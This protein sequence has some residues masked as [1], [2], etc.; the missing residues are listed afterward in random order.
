LNQGCPPFLLLSLR[1]L[2]GTLALFL[3]SRFLYTIRQNKEK[4][5]KFNKKGLSYGFV[6]GLLIFIVYG[7]QTV[8]ANYTTPAKNGVF[9]GLYII[10]V[11]IIIMLIKKHFVW[12]TFLLAISCFIGVIIVSDFFSERITINIGDILTI[13]C[14]II[15]AIYFIVL[16]KFLVCPDIDFFNFT[17]IQLFVVFV[18]SFL[19]SWIFENGNY[20]VVNWENAILWLL[21]LGIIA[22]ALTYYIQTLVQSIL[23]ANMVSVLSCSESLFSVIFSLLLGYNKF[24]LSLLFGTI[25]IIVSM[26]ATSIGRDENTIKVK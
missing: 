16:E 4:Y 21:F 6:A 18:F 11:P 25:I 3:F 23:S 10:F 26:M 7:L 24:S 15:I 1:F 2:F 8:G 19:T 20:G 22:T 9:T 13:F 5:R 17:T 12:K 14:A